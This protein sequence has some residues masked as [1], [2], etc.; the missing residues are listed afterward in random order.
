[1]T[2]K[3]AVAAVVRRNIPEAGGYTVFR[4]FAQQGTAAGRNEPLWWL[5]RGGVERPD[6]GFQQ[7][8]PRFIE[9]VPFQLVFRAHEVIRTGRRLAFLLRFL[10]M[11]DHAVA[12]VVIRGIRRLAIEL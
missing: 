12:E 11:R 6:V 3:C 4:A 2:R 10:R 1:M 7:K 9:R 8:T 5:L